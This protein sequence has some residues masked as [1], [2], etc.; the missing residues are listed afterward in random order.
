MRLLASPTDPLLVR[1]VSGLGGT[2]TVVLGSGIGAEV[3]NIFVVHSRRPL[4][5]GNP[6]GLW[7]VTLPGAGPRPTSP[8][9][10]VAAC[11]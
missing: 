4:K 5:L 3:Q 10:A 8:A 11:P 1:V 9:L 2:S 7:P 6:R